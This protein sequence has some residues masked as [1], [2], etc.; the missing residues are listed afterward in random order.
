MYGHGLC[1]KLH[2]S[3]QLT[4]TL[5]VLQAEGLAYQHT[6]YNCEQD[7]HHGLDH[8]LNPDVAGKACQGNPAEHSQRVAEAEEGIV[9]HRDGG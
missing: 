4:K 8:S 2:L 7:H 9:G 6:I 3:L 1:K 5:H